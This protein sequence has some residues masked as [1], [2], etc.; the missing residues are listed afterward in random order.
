MKTSTH[1]NEMLPQKIKNYGSDMT[2]VPKY[3]C[4]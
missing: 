1:M 3:S 2:C 4:V